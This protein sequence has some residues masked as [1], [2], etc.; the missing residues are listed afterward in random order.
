[1]KIPLLLLVLISLAVQAQNTPPPSVDPFAPKGK[2]MTRWGTP[3]QEKKLALL[4]NECLSMLGRKPEH[5]YIY[6]L[7]SQ[8]PH[9]Q[10]WNLQ[11]CETY[12]DPIEERDEMAHIIRDLNDPAQ[13]AEYEQSKKLEAI[14][15]KIYLQ[16][17]HMGIEDVLRPAQPSDWAFQFSR[18]SG[19][20]GY[21]QQLKES[22]QF[23]LNKVDDYY[24]AVFGSKQAEKEKRRQFYQQK[25]NTYGIGE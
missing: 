5:L 19:L 2:P 6:G 21:V 18:E 9:P 3:E 22:G 17:L 16:I 20:Y 4:I 8:V 13:K 14:Y 25:M 24:I 11:Y 10:N 7:P 1:M 15:K 23:D 12:A